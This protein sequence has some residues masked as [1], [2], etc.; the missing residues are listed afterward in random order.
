M[1][2]MQT[3]AL[4]RKLAD[5]VGDDLGAPQA[6][7]A[8]ETLAEADQVIDRALAGSAPWR[9]AAERIIVAR[10]A[11]ADALAAVA[12]SREVR[13]RSAQRTGPAR[14]KAQRP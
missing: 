9:E 3:A 13:R 5:G 1:R 12:A 11:V 6:R 8:L 7:H 4:R 2:K 14:P 10:S